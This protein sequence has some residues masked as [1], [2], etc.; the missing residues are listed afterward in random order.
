MSVRANHQP[1]AG[2][3]TNVADNPPP[4]PPSLPSRPVTNHRWS[5]TSVIST[6]WVKYDPFKG[7]P[8]CS[9]D[10]LSDGGHREN[11]ST[12]NTSEVER[13]A[14]KKPGRG[15][16]GGRAVE[17]QLNPLSLSFTFEQAT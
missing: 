14:V 16:F 1:Q 8:P 13:G 2:S 12:K 7:P 6:C 17:S 5:D 11:G 9:Q 10:G 3:V 4:T 15:P